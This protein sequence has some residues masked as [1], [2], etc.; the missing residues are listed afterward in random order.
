MKYDDSWT[1]NS[2]TSGEKKKKKNARLAFSFRIYV[3]CS[4]VLFKIGSGVPLQNCFSFPTLMDLC[5]HWFFLSLLPTLCRSTF[6]LPTFAFN[7]SDFNNPIHVTVSRQVD[8]LNYMKWIDLGKKRI[9]FDAIRNKLKAQI[10]FN[11]KRTI[12]FSLSHVCC[13]INLMFNIICSEFC[14]PILSLWI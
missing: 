11:V 4:N 3:E 1:L 8:E 13:S 5:I 9:D 10:E 7:L 6:D 12:F 2:K 14:F